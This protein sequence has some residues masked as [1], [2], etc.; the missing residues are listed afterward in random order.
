LN[1][2]LSLVYYLRIISYMYLKAPAGPKV[3][4]Q[5]GYVAALVLT[6]LAVFWIGVFPDGFIDWAMQAAAV[7]LP[8]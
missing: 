2:A 1:S 6:M 7:L 8:Q 4:E 5:K 3:A